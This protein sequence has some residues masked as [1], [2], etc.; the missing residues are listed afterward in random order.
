MKK[1]TSAGIVVFYQVNAHRE[2]LL[3]KYIA[4]H[5]DF[6][7]GK[8]ENGETQEQAAR[9]ELKEETGLH[10]IILLPGFKDSLV[11]IFNDFKGQPTEKIVHF[12][13]GQ[14]HKKEKIKLSRE[15]KEYLWLPY[16]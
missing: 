10:D 8:L 2:Y 13:V 12:F 6:P 5:W 7:K 16:E 3:L 11:Y 9:R 1:Q 15:H 4:G 14:V